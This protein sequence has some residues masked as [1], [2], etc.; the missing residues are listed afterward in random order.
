MT[1]RYSD[2]T[3]KLE[4]V[5][6]KSRTEGLAPCAVP[7]LK[8]QSR[9]MKLFL[10]SLYIWAR[11]ALIAAPVS[12]ILLWVAVGVTALFLAGPPLAIFLVHGYALV[13][14][15][16]TL[17]PLAYTETLQTTPNKDL[18]ADLRNIG[19]VLL[20]LI[21]L[22]LA[23]SRSVIAYQ[24]HRLS[25]NGL[26]I[27]RFQK[28]AQ[29]LESKDLS[30]RISGVFVLRDLAINSPNELFTVLDVLYAFVREKSKN[31]P[32]IPPSI[33]LANIGEPDKDYGPFPADLAEAL[34]ITSLLR[35]ELHFATEK[36]KNIGWKA[37]LRGAN[38]SRANILD[39]NLTGANL[40][41]TNMCRAIL[42]G[43]NL[44]DAILIESNL[45]RASLWGANLTRA[46]LSGSSLQ[47]ANL[48][49]A[50][51]S[52][53][54]FQACNVSGAILED[55]LHSEN[56]YLVGI[57]AF[58][59]NPPKKTPYGFSNALALRRTGED[60]IRFWNRILGERAQ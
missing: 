43:A 39:V 53:T 30:V 31:R 51:L 50:N 14:K 24:Q 5:N 2:F 3:A 45:N 29:M 54:D 60:K 35:G 8:S 4:A 10:N 57:W 11:K 47:G 7:P 21:G 16:W 25:E 49:A 37:N 32:T 33:D 6:A 34:K 59:D 13:S 18:F 15:L 58:V 52:N 56:A 36:A 46:N 40:A 17:G 27:D 44:T 42:R 22:P 9:A 38:L 41:N 20:G 26:I 23:I 12:K 55:V 28:G 19:L 1:E 48:W